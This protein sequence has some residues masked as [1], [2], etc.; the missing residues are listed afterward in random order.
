MISS[1]IGSQQQAESREQEVCRLTVNGIEI[2]AG[3][4]TLLL[5]EYPKELKS[6]TTWKFDFGWIHQRARC[7]ADS[8]HASWFA[9]AHLR[10]E[11]SLQA[12]GS[13]LRLKADK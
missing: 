6:N 1:E 3:M 2:V 4:K 5:C 12:A 11:C 13:S 8:C 7:H 10:L 9:V